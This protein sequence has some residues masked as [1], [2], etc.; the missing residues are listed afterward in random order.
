MHNNTG[1][2]TTAC[3]LIFLLLFF[4]ELIFL[5]FLELAET[6]IK[7]VGQRLPLPPPSPPPPA[8]PPAFGI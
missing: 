2:M 7:T 3:F 4:V 5:L 8:L 6:H 1:G